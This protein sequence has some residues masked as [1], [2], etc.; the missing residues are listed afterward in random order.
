[1]DCFCKYIKN[2]LKLEESSN[3][4]VYVEKEWMEKAF[5]PDPIIVEFNK[6]VEHN[7]NKD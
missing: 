5:L 2:F 7:M 3:L 1:M 6:V 4:V